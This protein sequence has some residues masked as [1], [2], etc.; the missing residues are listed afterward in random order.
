MLYLSVGSS[1]FCSLWLWLWEESDSLPAH[2]YSE[3]QRWNQY[4]ISCYSW[5]EGSAVELKSW[6]LSST[7]TSHACKYPPDISFRD[8]RTLALYGTRCCI[9]NFYNAERTLL[10]LIFKINWI[11]F[12]CPAASQDAYFNLHYCRCCNLLWW[13]VFDFSWLINIHKH[14]VSALCTLFSFFYL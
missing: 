7:P 10:K 3:P 2:L 5:G 13:F 8:C 9:S 6:R 11:F 14:I 4:Y 1:C 12:F